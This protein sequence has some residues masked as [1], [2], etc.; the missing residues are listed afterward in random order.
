MLEVDLKEVAKI[1]SSKITEMTVRIRKN[2]IIPGYDGVYEKLILVNNPKK[3]F[4]RNSVSSKIIY[5]RDLIR[6]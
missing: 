6:T 1:P 5:S 2:I 4:K 3:L